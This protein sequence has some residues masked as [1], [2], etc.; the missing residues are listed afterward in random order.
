MKLSI[1]AAASELQYRQDHLATILEFFDERRTFDP[2]LRGPWP[3]RATTRPCVL[4][5]RVGHLVIKDPSFASA[6]QQHENL[7]ST[8][9]QWPMALA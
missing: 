7:R 2:Q 5:A 9:P 4:R 6:A 8:A 1:S 3:L